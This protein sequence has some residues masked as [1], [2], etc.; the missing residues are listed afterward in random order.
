MKPLLKLS[1]LCS[2]V[3]S[4]NLV[5]S[6]VPLDKVGRSDLIARLGMAVSMACVRQM[7]SHMTVVVSCVWTVVMAVIG[8]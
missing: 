8:T 5:S 4:E 1:K 6:V 2:Y 7:S 3:I